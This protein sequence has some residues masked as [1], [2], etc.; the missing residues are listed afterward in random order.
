MKNNSAVILSYF[1][2]YSTLLINFTKILRHKNFAIISGM[3]LLCRQTYGHINSVKLISASHES[4]NI[5]KMENNYNPG[6]LGSFGQPANI[7]MGP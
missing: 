1:N 2:Q 6:D 5:P 4:R 7:C 3:G